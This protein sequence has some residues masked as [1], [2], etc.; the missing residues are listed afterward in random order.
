MDFKKIFIKDACPTKIGG[1]AVLEGIMMKGEDR[2]A[3]AVRTGSGRTYIR[4]QKSPPL[5]M[6]SKIPIVRGVYIFVSTLVV[7]MKTLIYSAEI[8]EEFD[9]EIS[10]EAA[11]E[12]LGAEISPEAIGEE[13]I[14]ES[15]DTV[16][17]APAES[18]AAEESE[19]AEE[20]GG[21]SFGTMIV[22]SVILAIALVVGVFIIVPTIVVNFA[23]Q[24][25]QNSILLNLFEGVFRIVLFVIYILAIS[26]M[27]DIKTVFQ[28]HGAEHKTIHC[29]ESGLD[30]TP[31]NADRFETLH[32]RCGT[33][34]L[35]FVMIIALLLFSLLGWP[36][37]LIRIAS[38]IVLIPVIAGLSYEL[39]RFAGRSTS[40][41]VMILSVPGLL[42]QKLTTMAPDKQQLEVA[43]AALK[44]V[45]VPTETPEIE[46][47][48]D[49]DGALLPDPPPESEAA[50]TAAAADTESAIDEITITITEDATADDDPILVNAAE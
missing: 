25:T 48:C 29:Y 8:L 27:K 40:P 34:F 1:Q 45:L 4:T 12:G 3:I 30:L 7:G 49:K 38:R 24:F 43:I 37:L 47:F 41:L 20:G 42:L 9:E 35:M 15:A 6:A 33:S 16:T 23:G 28:Y 36:N 46:G 44:G 13:A 50:E 17:V 31:E 21:I 39:L 18:E 22:L 5:G 2:T 32:P 14:G 10:E 26:H 11:G 19:E